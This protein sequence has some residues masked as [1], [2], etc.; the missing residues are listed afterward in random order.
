MFIT[1]LKLFLVQKANKKVGTTEIEARSVVIMCFHFNQHK[2]PK[3]SFL[4]AERLIIIAEIRDREKE[5][6]CQHKVSQRNRKEPR[7]RKEVF[8]AKKERNFL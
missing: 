8:E 6:F 3:V 4:E 7:W 5:N 2:L 1:V